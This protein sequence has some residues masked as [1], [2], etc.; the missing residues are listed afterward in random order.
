M[1]KRKDFFNCNFTPT[2]RASDLGIFC[3]NPSE[4]NE[5]Q[6]VLKYDPFFKYKSKVN[7]TKSKIK[8]NDTEVIVPKIEEISDAHKNEIKKELEANFLSNELKF[9]DKTIASK[10]NETLR[11]LLADEEFNYAHQLEII[12]D[13]R[14]QQ[15]RLSI[16]DKDELEEFEDDQLLINS[17]RK[18]ELE[19]EFKKFMFKQYKSLAYQ[20]ISKERGTQL[21]KRVIENINQKESMNF[22][23]KKS[24]LKKNFNSFRI[25][26][27][28]DG[29]DCDKRILIEVKTRNR[30]RR[31]VENL[32]PLEMIQCMC[33]MNLT[34][35]K[36][37]YLVE[38]DPSGEQ[39]VFQLEYDD[40]EFEEKVLSPLR[41]FA[42]KYREMT[43]LEFRRLI[44]KYPFL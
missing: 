39:N 34:G 15:K 42:N 29:M 21:E 43:E 25:C 17:L 24:L 40:V 32:S 30:L 6:F 10:F 8:L 1:S 41:K 19:Q 12:S 5:L 31:T 36:K 16:T 37:C 28:V 4:K 20:F 9:N 44:G 2:F 18:Y 7:L 35:C 23:Q 3:Q 26:G 33:Y 22:V 38:S 27:I 13:E 11:K 14:T